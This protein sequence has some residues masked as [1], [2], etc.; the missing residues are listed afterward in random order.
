MRLV[1]TLMLAGLLMAGCSSGGSSTVATRDECIEAIGMQF[2]SFMKVEGC[3]EILGND[4]CL[5]LAVGMDFRL[6]Q[7]QSISKIERVYASTC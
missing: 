4:W 3:E 5:A 2:T 6:E 7:G 1:I